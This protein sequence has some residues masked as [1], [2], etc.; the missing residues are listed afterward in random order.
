MS[1]RRSLAS[2]R[3]TWHRALGTPAW[4]RNAPAIRGCRG[5]ARPSSRHRK[6]PRPWAEALPVGIT[7]TGG[8]PGGEA[9]VSAGHIHNRARP[10]L[11]ELGLAVSDYSLTETGSRSNQLFPGPLGRRARTRSRTMSTA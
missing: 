11:F 10:Y 7:K 8:G 9:G 1:K 3:D 4:R 6:A 2:T 5:S